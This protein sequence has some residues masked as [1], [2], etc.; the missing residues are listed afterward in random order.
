MKFSLI[1]TVIIFF[2]TGF[3]YAA[4]HAQMHE[5]MMKQGGP[6]SDNRIELTLPGPAKIMHKEMMRQHM[7]TLSEI[8]AALAANDLDKV[9]EIT[10][11]NLGWSE[12]RKDQCSVF[13]PD[14]EGSDFTTLSTAMHKNAD[15]MTDAAK[16]GNMK[17]TLSALSDMITS[18]NNCHKT[19]RH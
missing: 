17:K 7:D 8:T 19:F 15:K 12:E 11:T 1:T 18:C 2:V 6:K 16:A 3:S 9:A 5:M 4:D 10:K 14:K 13:E